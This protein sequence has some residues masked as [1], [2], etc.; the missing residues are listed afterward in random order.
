MKKINCYMG[1]LGLFPNQVILSASQYEN[2]IVIPDTEVNVL[3]EN[4]FLGKIASI[5]Y[6]EH[7]QVKCYED[8]SRWKG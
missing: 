3:K 2:E 7:I 1:I 4:R 6:V 5:V 8:R